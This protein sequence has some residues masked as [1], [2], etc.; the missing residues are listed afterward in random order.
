[1]EKKEMNERFVRFKY[2]NIDSCI[3]KKEMNER[4]VRFKYENIDVCIALSSIRRFSRDEDSLVIIFE[5]GERKEWTFKNEARAYN[6]FLG[7]LN[8]IDS[9]NNS[10]VYEIGGK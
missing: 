2:E 7:I 5:D 6:V 3:T 8:A 9:R 4:F 10:N 1:M